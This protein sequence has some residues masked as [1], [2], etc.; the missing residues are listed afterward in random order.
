MLPGFVPVPAKPRRRPAGEA[1]MRRALAILTEQRVRN[2]PILIHAA[3]EGD[4]EE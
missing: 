2:C 1:E 4:T 3:R